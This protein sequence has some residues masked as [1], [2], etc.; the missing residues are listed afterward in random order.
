MCDALPGPD[1]NFVISC[2][3]L[4][5]R[6]RC[7]HPILQRRKQ[8]LTELVH[9]FIVVTVLNFTHP[10]KEQ[11]FK[12]AP[13]PCL[14]FTVRSGQL[15]TFTLFIY[16]SH[17]WFFLA[18]FSPPYKSR[19]PVPLTLRTFPD[20]MV[21][22]FFLLQLFSSFCYNKSIF[23][24]PPKFR[25]VFILTVAYIYCVLILGQ[26]GPLLNTE[27]TICHLFLKRKLYACFL[28]VLAF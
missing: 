1:G 6:G 28:T 3:F 16:F 4:L 18:L 14:W 5:I 2:L 21:G 7:H 26:P 9:T 22:M 23:T 19:V 12:K 15:H 25:V 27:Q 10:G 20:L 11:R 13:L 8:R 24:P 17:S